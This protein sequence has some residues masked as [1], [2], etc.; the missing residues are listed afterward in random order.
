MDTNPL[1]RSVAWDLYLALDLLAASHTLGN[2]PAAPDGPPGDL[3]HA[4][5]RLAAHQEVLEI[6]DPA[7]L[8]RIQA[9]LDAWDERPADR[10]I[11]LLPLR[12]ELARRAGAVLPDTL[13]PV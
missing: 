7:L 10:L 4:R 8:S 3:A 11:Q 13:P 9:V 5:A 1:D 6:A 12:D 2:L